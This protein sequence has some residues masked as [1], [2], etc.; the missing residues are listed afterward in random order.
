MVVWIGLHSGRFSFFLVLLGVTLS[1]LGMLVS[2]HYLFIWMCLVL[3][4]LSTTGWLSFILPALPLSLYF[5]SSALGGLLFV[6]SSYTSS[7]PPLFVFLALLL[8]LGFFP[9]QFWSFSV[10]ANLP[11]SKTCIFQG[12]MK[13]GYL[14]LLLECPLNLLWVG[15]VSFITGLILIFTSMKM[16]ALLWG[17]S[18]TLLLQVLL[19]DSFFGFLFYVVYSSTMLCLSYYVEANFSLLIL[20]CSLAGMPPLSM[21]WPKLLAI[22][23][24]PF[25]HCMVLLFC[26][27]L[28][29]YPYFF[30][31]LA[32]PSYSLPSFSSSF[33]LNVILPLSICLPVLFP[34]CV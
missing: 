31:G 30:F 26:S 23:N 25:L 2:S 24:L 22:F 16:W 1:V 33:L 7:L 27:A 3:G 20:L 18:S 14:F 34:F 9:F 8:L 4:T 13:L 11:L 21:F 19:L 29:L 12:P 6:F 15:L 32:I 10:L 17:S 28:T 5:V